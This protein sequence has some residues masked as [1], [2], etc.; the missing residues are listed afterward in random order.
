MAVFMTG[1]TGFLG[2]YL[3]HRLIRA[4]E[5]L[6]LLIRAPDH[7]TARGRVLECLGALGDVD[8]AQLQRQVRVCLGRLEAPGLGLSPA[9][10]EHVLEACDQFLHCGANVHFNLSLAE[11][12]AVNVG[13]TLS[14]LELALQ[15]RRRGNARLDHIS[16]AYV[17]GNR[18]DLVREGELDGR[19]GH[20]NTYERAKFEAELAL[21]ERSGELA[22][23]VFRPS[24]IAGDSETGWTS[25]FDTIYWPTKVYAHGLWRTCFGNPETP[26]DLVPVNFVSDAIL[27][28]R[29]RQD[30]IGRCFHLAAGPE[31]A[32][33]LGQ[34]F[35]LGP[36]LF[37]NRKPVRFVSPGWWLRYVLP[38]LRRFSVGRLRYIV[39]AGEFYLPYLAHN[40]Q[41]DNSSAKAL[42]EDSGIE[43]PSVW[44]YVDR[45]ARY[46]MDT[47]WGRKVPEVVSRDS[48][49][50]VP[51]A[52]DR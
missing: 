47:D 40:P 15:R 26:L 19:L 11:A 20:K 8:Q 12:R 14:I 30:A 41:F 44:G 49:A 48:E 5:H 2:R 42:L 6:I 24:M 21:R 9:D 1:A 45:L 31:R 36:R 32:I 39:R 38:V 13:G 23:T 10:R 18:T 28:L 52:I 25:S 22:V 43:V 7:Q 51:D 33:T 27:A 29:Q 17:A 16:T 4:G 46:G 37:P 34:L 50:G 35:E 3:A